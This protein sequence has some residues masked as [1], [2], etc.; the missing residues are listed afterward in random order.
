MTQTAHQHDTAYNAYLSTI[1]LPNE[2]LFAT[3]IDLWP[4]YLDSFS[5]PADRQY[6]NCHTCRQFIQR[7][8]NLV[9]INPDTG[10]TKTAVWDVDAAPQAYEAAIAAM[11]TAAESAQ[12]TGVFLSSDKM[13]GTPVTG[14]WMHFAARN[15]SVYKKSL[16]TAGQAAAE[17]K[18][19]YRNVFRALGEFKIETLEQVTELLQSDALYRSEKVLGQA[20]W[21]FDLKT[22]T[23]QTKHQMQRNNIIWK[24]IADAPAGFCH[25]R[26]SMIGT[27]LDDLDS[28]LPFDDA[29]RKFKAKM[30]PLKYQRPSAA[31]TA[32][33]IAAAEKMVKE[34]G[35]EPSLE[36]RYATIEDMQTIWLPS[37]KAPKTGGVF[38]HLKRDARNPVA[39]VAGNITWLKFAAEVLPKA[40]KIEVQVP[41]GHAGFIVFVTA[42]SEDAPC[43]FQW[44]NPVSWYHW[45]GGAPASQFGLN[46]GWASAKAVCLPP[47]MWCDLNPTHYGNRVAFVLEGARESRNEGNAIFPEMLKSEFHAIRSVIEAHS[48]RTKIHDVDGQHVVGL[49]IGSTVR[50][51][52]SVVTQYHID[53]WD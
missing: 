13:L 23:G 3:D 40:R 48:K 52:T 16:L 37:D 20:Q 38:D 22:S 32:G 17:K 45:H 29:A 11:K 46:A 41:H 44:G 42:Q 53:R 33:A 2:A 28:G 49:G 15:P 47:Y 10:E 7:Y 21:L 5:E 25:P 6:H 9:T 36:R 27:L 50:V 14:A 30:H 24:A 34:L 1:A 4:I 26:S 18:E 19:D 31:P 8:G 43:I 12:V 51:H 35:V 39:A